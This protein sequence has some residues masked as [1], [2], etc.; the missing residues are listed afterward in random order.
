MAIDF[1]WDINKAASNLR[2]H[3]VSF[4][5]AAQVF[6]DPRS[7]TFSDEAHSTSEDRLIT[8][9]ASKRLKVLLVVHTETSRFEGSVI[10][11]IIS[12]RRATAGERAVY[13]EK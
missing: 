3:R 8:I 11:R 5:E 1:E 6:L 9:G 7:V 13:E 12:A 4:E 10:I 2:T